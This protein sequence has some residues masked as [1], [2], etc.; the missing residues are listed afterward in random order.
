[1]GEPVVQSDSVWLPPQYCCVNSPLVSA[2]LA[3]QTGSLPLKQVP[4]AIPMPIAE[5]LR[6]LLA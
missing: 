2:C 1:M 5:M 6:R 4:L 3:S